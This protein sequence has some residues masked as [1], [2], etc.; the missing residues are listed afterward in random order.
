MTE[1][2]GS[3]LERDVCADHGG[4]A[5]APSSSRGRNTM[6]EPVFDPVPLGGEPLPRLDNL[7]NEHIGAGKD[8]DVKYFWHGAMLFAFDGKQNNLQYVN[9]LLKKRF[10]PVRP[11]S[12]IQ[13]SAC[14]KSF[15]NP[16]QAKNHRKGWEINGVCD[17]ERSSM[18]LGFSPSAFFLTDVVIGFLKRWGSKKVDLLDA[19][20]FP[21][22][23]GGKPG[24]ATQLRPYMGLELTKEKRQMS[25]R[26]QGLPELL[27][28]KSLHFW[29]PSDKGAARKFGPE[30]FQLFPEIL[31]LGFLRPMNMWPQDLAQPFFASYRATPDGNNYRFQYQVADTGGGHDDM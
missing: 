9:E 23:V 4:T 27:A 20:Q 22:P 21:F 8:V 7:T 29:S 11:T 2:A 10:Y 12:P 5:E 24:P 26:N 13:C 3:D 31:H 28:H 30:R 19:F 6:V 16:I 18:E 15:Y 14:S 17:P 25:I 1:P